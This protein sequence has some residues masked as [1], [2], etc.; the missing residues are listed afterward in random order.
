MGEAGRVTTPLLSKQATEDKGPSGRSAATHAE[1]AS[2]QA[3]HLSNSSEDH[4]CGAV[5]NAEIDEYR[6]GMFDWLKA[7]M[8]TKPLLRQRT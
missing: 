1:A 4:L 5:S 3:D 6:E 2:G 7:S 8:P